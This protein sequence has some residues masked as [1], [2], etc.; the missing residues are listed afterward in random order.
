MKKI[1]IVLLLLTIIGNVYSKSLDI[2][3]NYI[4]YVNDNNEN[5]F[6]NLDHVECIRV[7]YTSLY[8]YNVYIYIQK[9]E[10]QIK[11]ITIKEMKKFYRKINR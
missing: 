7:V 1:L 3:R 4:V 9:H 6:Y 5:V 2:K 10:I 11:E 8:Y